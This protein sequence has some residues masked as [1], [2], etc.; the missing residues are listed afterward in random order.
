MNKLFEKALRTAMKKQNLT[1]GICCG[2]GSFGRVYKLYDSN[3][4]LFGV[5]K[6]ALFDDERNNVVPDRDNIVINHRHSL[7]KEF[8]VLRQMSRCNYTVRLKQ[9]E[10][11]PLENEKDLLPTFSVGGYEAGYF[12]EEG[13]ISLSQAEEIINAWINAYGIAPVIGYLGYAVSSALLAAQKKWPGFSHRDIKPSNIFL[14]LGASMCMT[15]I[16]FVLG[17]YGICNISPDAL[18][19]AANIRN[20]EDEFRYPDTFPSLESDIYSLGCV[21]AY[22]AGMSFNSWKGCKKAS[23]LGDIGLFIER[24]LSNDKKCRP[25][26]HECAEMFSNV[27]DLYKDRI[28][29]DEKN[30]TCAISAFNAGNPNL[31]CRPLDKI[32]AHRYNGIAKYLIGDL[33][34]ARAEFN[35]AG[36]TISMFYLT[37]MITS[38]EKT[39]IAVENLLKLKNSLEDAKNNPVYD[40]ILAILYSLGYHLQTNEQAT[41]KAVLKR[42]DKMFSFI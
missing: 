35:A 8:N 23:D 21:L 20:R 33:I 30:C 41:A 19:A 4:E 13:L 28:S 42:S 10:T 9:P 25:T 17:D 40:Y 18:T 22:F 32:K 11:S 24:M 37:S 14:R 2:E 6:A 7:S 15:E 36:D 34:A 39:T 12:I 26:L 5:V 38:D 27:K 31:V 1:L 16:V 3:G 29:Q